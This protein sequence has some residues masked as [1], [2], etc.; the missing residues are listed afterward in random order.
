MNYYDKSILI[1]Y[2]ILNN[3]DNLDVKNKV[4]FN[5]FKLPE[6]VIKVKVTKI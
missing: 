5:F 1:D 4:L 3:Y 6:R 2:M